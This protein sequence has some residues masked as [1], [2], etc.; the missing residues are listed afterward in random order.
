[1]VVW[2]RGGFERAGGSRKKRLRMLQMCRWRA[3]GTEEQHELNKI[4][5]EPGKHSEGRALMQQ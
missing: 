5:E 1:M 4:V 3:A 2:P